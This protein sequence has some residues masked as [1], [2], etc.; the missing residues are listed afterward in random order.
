MNRRE[1]FTLL[2]GAATAWPLGARA[3]AGDASDRLSLDSASPDRWT[4]RLRAVHQGLGETG[5][6]ECLHLA[7]EC[8]M[9]WGKFFRIT[10]ATN[11][12]IAF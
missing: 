2:G 8:R 6:V 7:I 11:D 5:Y 12:L 9:P 4:D 10:R 1:F 3:A